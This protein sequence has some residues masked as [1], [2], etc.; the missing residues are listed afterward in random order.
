MKTYWAP[1]G[2]EWS[3]SRPGHSVSGTHW[4]GGWVGP[5]APIWTRWQGEKFPDPSGN[6]ASAVQPVV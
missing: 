5:R 6:R 4:K 1:G 2:G 3:A